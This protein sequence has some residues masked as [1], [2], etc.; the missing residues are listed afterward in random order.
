MLKKEVLGGG[1]SV[2]YSVSWRLVRARKPLRLVGRAPATPPVLDSASGTILLLQ[3]LHACSKQRSWREV[4]YDYCFC[5]IVRSG[6]GHKNSCSYE[7]GQC[8]R[9]CETRIRKSPQPLPD[10]ETWGSALSLSLIHSIGSKYH[11]RQHSRW[12]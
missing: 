1:A 10:L 9:C 12:L 5:T 11:S 8:C 3:L 6:K 7:I 4:G 2:A